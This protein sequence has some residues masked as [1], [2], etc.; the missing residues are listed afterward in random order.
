MSVAPLV[1]VGN[2]SPPAACSQLLG[3]VSGH[4]VDLVGL[5]PCHT[6]QL[7]GLSQE[8]PVIT[9]PLQWRRGVQTTVDKR[10]LP[11]CGQMRMHNLNV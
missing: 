10:L 9:C 7:Q 2:W 3:L 8:H 11:G 4:L 6:P 1:G 5:L